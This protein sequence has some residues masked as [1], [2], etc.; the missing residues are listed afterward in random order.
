MSL[1]VFMQVWWVIG[2]VPTSTSLTIK[3]CVKHMLKIV[4]HTLNLYYYETILI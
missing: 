3:F 1:I 4:K 2:A